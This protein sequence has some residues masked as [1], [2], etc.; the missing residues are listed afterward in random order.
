MATRHDQDQ[1]DHG[2][3]TVTL[4]HRDGTT[5]THAAD[6]MITITWTETVD[7]RAHRSLG[8]L[9]DLLDG[10]AP[11]VD[12]LGRLHLAELPDNGH[13]LVGDLGDAPFE[14]DQTSE[15]TGY[16]GPGFNRPSSRPPT[17]GRPVPIAPS[18]QTRPDRTPD[19]VRSGRVSLSGR[20]ARHITGISGTRHTESTEG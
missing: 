14:E 3:P 10:A 15:V 19:G 9:L 7:Y 1:Q 16:R 12:D 6:H 17:P 20:R 2:N 13:L 8:D 11:V 4:V 18:P 5:S